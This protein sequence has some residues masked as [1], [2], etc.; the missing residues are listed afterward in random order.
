VLQQT[1]KG[2]V[3]LHQRGILHLD[4]KAAN[5]MLMHPNT[6]TIINH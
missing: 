4:I 5:S 1:L 3:H 2:L 6:V